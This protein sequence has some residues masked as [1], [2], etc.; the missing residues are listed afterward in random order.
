MSVEAFQKAGGPKELAWIEGAS[1]V[2][3]Y[4]KEQYVT[5]AVEKLGDFFAAQLTV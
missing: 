1:H 2:D 5:P 4:D 3:L